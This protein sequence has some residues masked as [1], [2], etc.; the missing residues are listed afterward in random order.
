MALAAKSVAHISP[1][2]LA[3]AIAVHPPMPLIGAH[4]TGQSLSGLSAV[5]VCISM[6]TGSRSVANLDILLNQCQPLRALRR[7]LMGAIL[8][9]ASQPK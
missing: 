6:K 3:I 8:G 1:V 7:T 5:W 4:S 2:A 9:G